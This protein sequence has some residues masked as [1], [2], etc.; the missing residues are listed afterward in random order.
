MEKKDPKEIDIELELDALY[1]KV[2]GAD[3]PGDAHY[4]LQQVQIRAAVGPEIRDR[5]SSPAQEK[6]GKTFRRLRNISGFIFLILILGLFALFLWPT[7]Y[8]Y[9]ALNWEGKV[10]PLR[11]N[12]LTGE[13]SY[14]DGSAWLRTPLTKAVE[15]P[16]GGDPNDPSAVVVP[17]EM[18]TVE[19]RTADSADGY[20]SIIPRDAS[21]K[22][23]SS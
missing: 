3:Q 18:N 10:Y 11:I 7:I 16:V 9:N 15:E 5:M 14:F 21:P 1:R 12:R 23:G 4:P 2:A 17:P 22:G 6:A 19:P 8:D 20:P 13:S